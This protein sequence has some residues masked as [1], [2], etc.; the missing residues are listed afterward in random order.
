MIWTS[1]SISKLISKERLNVRKG[2]G[3]VM[4]RTKWVATPY[5]KVALGVLLAVHSS[6]CGALEHE[7]LTDPTAAFV[8]RRVHFPPYMKRRSVLTSRPAADTPGCSATNIQ[9]Y[10]EGKQAQYAHA[11]C[12][13]LFAFT[14]GV[15]QL[16]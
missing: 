6:H 4:L 1:I 15:A 7:S 16:S 11:L 8:S 10:N 5:A 13:C 14:T 12:W 9:T 2:E 3:L